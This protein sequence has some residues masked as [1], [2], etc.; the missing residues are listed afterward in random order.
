MKRLMAR[1]VA[2]TAAVV[3]CG[4]GLMPAAQASALP[5]LYASQGQQAHV[6]GRIG[7]LQGEYEV[8][9][10]D[11]VTGT[12]STGYWAEGRIELICATDLGN[13]TVQ[14]EGA[15]GAFGMFSQQTAS[16]SPTGV[17]CGSLSFSP[18]GASCQSSQRN[19]WY[20]NY[21]HW[22]D[23]L[24]QCT[25]NIN[26]NNAVWTVAFPHSDAVDA[27]TEIATVAYTKVLSGSL[28]TGHFWICP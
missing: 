25:S 2:A 23:N 21:M 18:N 11:I 6:C 7:D 19:V 12:D 1:L 13:V 4:F 14:C 8:V 16:S 9:C 27:T 28:N 17:A 15:Q 5:I 22:N 10:S 20:T 26:G 24:T 3:L